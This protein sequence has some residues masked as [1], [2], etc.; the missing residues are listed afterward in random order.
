MTDNSKATPRPW[1][2]DPAGY[3]E[4]IWGPNDEMIAMLRGVGQGLN[5]KAHRDLILEAVNSYDHLRRVEILA[6]ELVALIGRLNWQ[7]VTERYEVKVLDLVT[8]RKA[9]ELEAAIGEKRND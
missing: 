2:G 4:Y 3:A 1:H 6:G 8:E 5:Q 9:C 7:K